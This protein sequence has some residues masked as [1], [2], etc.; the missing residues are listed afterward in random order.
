MM[1]DNHIIE[2][3]DGRKENI[4]TTSGPLLLD[5]MQIIYNNSERDGI[6][7]KLKADSDKIFNYINKIRKIKDVLTFISGPGKN[8]LTKV[9]GPIFEDIENYKTKEKYIRY[10]RTV[11]FV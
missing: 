5:Q 10:G 3:P 9:Q 7:N 11:E 6:Q 2:Y 4:L 1:S 8:E